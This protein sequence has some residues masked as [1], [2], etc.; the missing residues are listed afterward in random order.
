MAFYDPFLPRLVVRGEPPRNPYP[1]AGGVKTTP[2]SHRRLL[3][4]PEP[5]GLPHSFRPNVHGLPGRDVLVEE[6]H[7]PT[8]HSLSFPP[9]IA[10]RTLSSRS[11]PARTLPRLLCPL[12]LIFFRRTSFPLPLFLAMPFSFACKHALCA[13]VRKG[14]FRS[15]GWNMHEFCSGVDFSLGGAFC[16]SRHT[17]LTTIWMRPHFASVREGEYRTFVPAQM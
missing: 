15:L 13:F 9:K 12:F 14:G 17:Y 6:A 11:S 2:R 10:P 4:S 1:P 8:P 5:G 7:S 16:T 3:L